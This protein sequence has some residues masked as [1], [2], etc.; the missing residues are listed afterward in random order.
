MAEQRVERRLA[1]ILAGDVA[2]YSRLMGVD[3]E[4]TLSRLNAHRREFLEPKIADYRGRIVKRT[5]DGVLIEF[6]SAVDATR[7][8]VEIQRGM[9][10]RNAPVPQGRHIELRIGIHVGD[11]SIED[12]DIFG[13]GV[14]IAARLEGIAQPGGICISEDAYRQVHGKLDTTFRDAGEHQL[15]NIAQPV[16]IYQLQ[17][18]GSPTGIAGPTLPQKPSI[19][20]LPFQNMSDDP[21]Q[22]YFADG[23]VEELITGLSRLRWLFVTSRT[24]SFQFKGQH[25][26]MREIAKRLNVR[27]VLEGSVRKAGTRLRIT[28]QLIDAA[29]GAHIW[30]ERYD[31]AMD[32]IF[33][34]QD[35]ITSNVV[36]AIEPSVRAA[37]IE[38]ATRKRPENLDAYDCYLRALAQ[39]YRATRES[40]DEGV[41]LLEIAL[42]LDQ[43]YVPAS[44]LAA[45][46]YFLRVLSGWTT[47]PQDEA[48]RGLHQ[49]RAA[50]ELGRDDPVALSL[51]GWV[52]ATLGHDVEAGVAAA[53]Q[54]VHLSPNSAQVVD[55]LGYL[56]T[57]S[58]NQETAL[59]RFAT[60]VRLSP[61]DPVSY[62]FNTG[63]GIACLLMGRY[64]D[65]VAFCEKARRSHG[66]WGP[67]FRIL[68]AGYAHLGQTQK[69]SEALVRY[70]ELEPSASIAHLRRQ[71]PYR[72]VEQAEHLWEGLR[73]AG[74]PE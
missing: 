49:A 69:A 8:A 11:I 57:L 34:L 68:A 33:D 51:A 58:G 15:K 24:S 2:G 3:E 19:A 28:G 36:S 17:Q 37:E 16:R 44:A 46:F 27:Y 66:K 20:V 43:S 55:L 73:K 9:I 18:N 40:C 41:R 53:E 25:V 22:E 5:G 72:N 56:L 26:D 31:G 29:T 12:G 35:K 67:I 45:W 62:R 38:R 52:V 30:A 21:G 63:A 54:A 4:G 10:E 47:S 48:A 74:L 42:S 60:A 23:I 13:D 65:A 59:E 32:D 61:G 1:A 6:A 71:L 50:L 70:R 7:C 39:H 14:N 64:D